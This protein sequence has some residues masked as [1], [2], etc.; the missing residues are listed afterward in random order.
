MAKLRIQAIGLALP[1]PAMSGAEADRLEKAVEKVL[2]DGV[3]TA[4]LLQAEGAKPASTS[5]AGDAV[6]AALDASL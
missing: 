1:C 4:D 2:A 5:E 3:R 6:L